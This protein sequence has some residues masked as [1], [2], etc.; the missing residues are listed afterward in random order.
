[1]TYLR[2]SDDADADQDV[3][4]SLLKFARRNP[5]RSPNSARDRRRTPGHAARIDNRLD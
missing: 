4:V 3:V 5:M 2:R 1:M